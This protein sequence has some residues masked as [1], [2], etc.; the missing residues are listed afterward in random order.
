[1]RLFR[2]PSALHGQLVSVEQVSG[3]GVTGL[4]LMGVWTDE[5]SVQIETHTIEKKVRS[6]TQNL[7]R[8]IQQ[9]YMFGQESQSTWCIFEGCFPLL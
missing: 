7:V 8:S 4:T 2:H 1:M 3:V 5:I 6:H 9:K